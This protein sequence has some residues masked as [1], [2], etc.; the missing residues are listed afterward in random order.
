[1]RPISSERQHVA[2]HCSWTSVST[3]GT[4]VALL[5]T[6]GSSEDLGLESLVAIDLS[7]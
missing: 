6:R 1:M 7:Q 2:P 4:R 5:R 3:R